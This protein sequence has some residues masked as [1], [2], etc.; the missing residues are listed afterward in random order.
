MFQIALCED[1]KIYAE[2]QERLCREILDGMN[3]P[4]A[5][6]EYHDRR[7]CRGRGRREKRRLT[8]AP[9]LT[10]RGLDPRGTD[11]N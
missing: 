3:V 4:Y 7:S 11:H 6:S 9:E 10:E 1:E 5:R 2:T 8:A